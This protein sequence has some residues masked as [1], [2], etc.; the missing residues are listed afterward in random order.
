GDPVENLHRLAGAYTGYVGAHPRL[1]GVV[2]E[3]RMPQGETPQWYI[4]K[5]QRLLGLVEAAIAPL[6]RPGDEAARHHEAR[7]LWASMHGIVTLDIAGKGGIG[8]SA[9]ALANSLIGNYVAGL[10][11]R[12]EA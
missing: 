5:V 7:V 2:F 10:R 3:H 12:G 9:Q 4:E 11:A 8:E 6:F 1:W